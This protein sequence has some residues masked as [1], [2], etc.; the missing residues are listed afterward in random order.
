MA[1]DV[2]TKPVQRY[3]SHQIGKCG[4]DATDVNAECKASYL[5]LLRNRNQ[6]KNAFVCLDTADKD[7]VQHLRLPGGFGQTAI[8]FGII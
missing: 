4:P 8:V 2:I 1:S 7:D 6:V 5:E 3:L